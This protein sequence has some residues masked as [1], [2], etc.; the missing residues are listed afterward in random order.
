MFNLIATIAIGISAWTATTLIDVNRRVSAMEA[1]RFTS[2]DGLLIWREVSAIR[3]QIAVIPKESPPKW[4]KD[5]VDRLE[6]RLIDIEQ[7]QTILLQ[8]TMP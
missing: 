2:A 4:F 5:Q 1:N 8:R 6:S 3:E 7:K